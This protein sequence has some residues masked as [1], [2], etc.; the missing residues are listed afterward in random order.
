MQRLV[1][2]GRRLLLAIG[3]LTRW[4]VPAHPAYSDHEFTASSRYYPL[5]GLLI[6]GCLWAVAGIG[7]ALGYPPLVVAALMV[8]A[9]LWLTGALHE[10]GL[11]D[12]ADGLGGGQ[13]RAARLR[14]MKD[15]R[16][17]TYGAVALTMALL[18]R[19]CCLANLPALWVVA[20]AQGWSRALA[21]VLMRLLPYARD[22]ADAKLKPVAQG[23]GRFNVG[24]ALIIGAIPLLWLPWLTALLVVATSVV[25]VWWWRRQLRR[26]IGGY[27][28]DA[29]GAIQQLSELLCYLVVLAQWGPLWWS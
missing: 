6:G 2:E 13:D 11:A 5:V 1:G 17:G 21:V 26:L 25:L 12:C 8:G 19:V 24:L 3:L 27:T 10:D 29:L 18:L 9:G 28:G 15:S 22:E 4:P 7:S 14:I 20:I 16:I 23:A